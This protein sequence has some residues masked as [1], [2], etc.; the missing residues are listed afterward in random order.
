M[1]QSIWFVQNA[2]RRTT[3]LVENLT[4]QGYSVHAAILADV[5]GSRLQHAGVDLALLAADPS[6]LPVWCRE[7]RLQLPMPL[8]W[9]CEWSGS[10]T[11]AALHDAPIDGIVSPGMSP[12]EM[13]YALQLSTAHFRR[14]RQWA[15]EREQLLSRLEERKVIERAKSILCE[16]K[17]ISEEEAYAFLR[18]Q[19]MSERKRLADIAASIVNVYRLLRD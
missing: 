17:Q 8:V 13:Q 4:T 5:A 18:K 3:E 1:L 14:G 12:A 2:D 15:L 7:I 19:A 6:E 10:L 11:E 16:I 9:W